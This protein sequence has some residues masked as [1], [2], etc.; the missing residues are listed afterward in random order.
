MDQ[1]S[2]SIRVDRVN[3]KQVFL[4]NLTQGFLKHVKGYVLTIMTLRNE[5]GL[6]APEKKTQ[7]E[8]SMACNTDLVVERTNIK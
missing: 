3:G 5:S 6:V 7:R 2:E 4:E 8:Q 1:W